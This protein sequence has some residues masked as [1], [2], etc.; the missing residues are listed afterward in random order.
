MTMGIKQIH[1]SFVVDVIPE[2]NGVN[3]G[4]IDVFRTRDY[5]LFSNR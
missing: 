5:E 4:R 2:T 3:G 1:R